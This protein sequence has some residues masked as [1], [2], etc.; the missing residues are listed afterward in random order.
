MNLSELVNATKDDEVEIAGERISITFYTHHSPGMRAE[1]LREGRI[2][3][4][5][6]NLITTPGVDNNASMP[7][8]LAARLKA[9]SLPSESGEVAPITAELL[10]RFRDEHFWPLWNKVYGVKGEVPTDAS[11]SANG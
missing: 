4:E 2:T 8:V 7:I 1:A 5:E 9:W 11:A 3:K 10:S 6:F